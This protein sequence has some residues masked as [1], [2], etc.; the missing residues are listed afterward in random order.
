MSG[1]ISPVV[2]VT[3]VFTG[4]AGQII[5]TAINVAAP[6]KTLAAG[7]ILDKPHESPAQYNPADP[8]VIFCIQAG[9]III[10]ARVLGYFLGK[11]RQPKVIAEVIAGILLYALPFE[12]F[13][14]P[15]DASCSGPS[16]FG[17]IP[18]FSAA[19]FPPPT[20]P[21]LNLVATLGLCLFLFLI[22][23]ETDFSIF[24][25]NARTSIA[26][27]AVGMVFPFGL[28]AAVAVGL[29]NEVGFVFGGRVAKLS[30]SVVHRHGRSQL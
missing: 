26:I 6:A 2:T 27:S 20:L 21:Y 4:T 17:R 9:L 11:I 29:Y 14:R 3:K 24:K 7:S 23:I 25:R 22:G 15:I 13:R 8:I 30:L 1:T 5:S 12:Y 18:G 19:I 10:L 28:G 16:V